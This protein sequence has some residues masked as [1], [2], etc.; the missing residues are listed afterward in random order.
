[1][2]YALILIIN[3]L[4]WYVVRKRHHQRRWLAWYL[5]WPSKPYWVHEFMIHVASLCICVI[6]FYRWEPHGE[7][8]FLGWCHMY[9]FISAQHSEPHLYEHLWWSISWWIGNR[10]GDKRWTVRILGPNYLS[11]NSRSGI[12][13]NLAEMS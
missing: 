5:R 12:D 3:V 11:R 6:C 1:M 4:S 9:F 8:P 2:N 13:R 10:V 7:S